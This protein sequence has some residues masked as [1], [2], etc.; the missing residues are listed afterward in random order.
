MKTAAKIIHDTVLLFARSLLQQ[1]IQVPVFILTAKVLGP[2]G[3]GLL[4][5]LGIV[6]MLSKYG[7][8]D[9]A[10]V[11]LREVAENTDPEGRIKP[12]VAR[13]VAY[14]VNILWGAGLTTAV[15]A[16]SF[17]TEGGSEMAW[18]LRIGAVC[19]MLSTISR[20]MQV[21]CSL[22]RNFS[23]IAKA[24][25]ADVLVSATFTIASIWMLGVLSPLLAAM[26][27]CMF[28][29]YWLSTRVGLGLRPAL[30]GAEVR[31]Q[32]V[33][34]FPMALGTM[35]SGA[36]TWGERVLVGALWGMAG[37][38]Y[39]SFLMTVVSIA[40]LLLNNL[41]QAGSTHVYHR[42]GN[43]EGPVAAGRLIDAPTLSLACLTPLLA[44]M[45]VFWVA[46]LVEHF[47][48]DFARVVPLLPLMAA[49][50]MLSPL[51]NFY[52]GALNSTRFNAQTA[53]LVV[54]LASLGVFAAGCW[55]A[56]ELGAGVEG[57]MAARIVALVLSNLA[58]IVIA[59]RFL[60]PGWRQT[61]FKLIEFHLPGV[62]ACGL[63][64][65][66]NALGD[67]LWLRVA[68]MP[69]LFVVLYSPV[70]VYWEK[71]TALIRE[72]FLPRIRLAVGRMAGRG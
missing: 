72:F 59:A 16:W 57:A 40:C 50:L 23:A 29:L 19:L 69:M 9:F 35:V 70:L 32:A 2:E 58:T 31:R 13:N 27:A 3:L 14:T 4:R 61:A 39:F 15:L 43:R 47:M 24:G 25:M 38:G 66:L 53:N 44:A 63:I 49:V 54:G 55:M 34:A 45:A 11:I 60:H 36:Q 28:Q 26:L 8:I 6:P 10:S 20:L 21:N 71:R 1:I 65:A 56:A 5:L 17:V 48:P 67:D 12:T 22:E 62:V 51:T 52:G 33:I 68:G 46:P 64:V 41:S 30:D 42:F 37:L 18:G 7:S